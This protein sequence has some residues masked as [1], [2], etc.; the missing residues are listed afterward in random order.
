MSTDCRYWWRGGVLLTLIAALSAPVHA[1]WVYS[2]GGVAPTAAAFDPQ[3]PV[4]VVFGA[5][6]GYLVDVSDPVLPR[7]QYWGSREGAPPISLPSVGGARDVAL[8][9]GRLLVSWRWRSSGAPKVT[10]FDVSDPF[11]IWPGT[12]VSGTLPGDPQA[13]ALVNGVAA[14]AYHVSSSASDPVLVLYALGTGYSL[15]EL[16]RVSIAGA[17]AAAPVGER[18]AVGGPGGVD[19]V[20]LDDP[21]T[22]MVI[23]HL[24]QIVEDLAFNGTVLVARQLIDA[25]HSRLLTIDV[26]DPTDP[27]LLGVLEGLA[28]VVSLATDGGFAYLGRAIDDGGGWQGETVVVS[29][30]DPTVPTVVGTIATGAALGVAVRDGV[31]VVAA[32]EQG[33]RV[34]RLDGPAQLAAPPV[35][36]RARW[37]TDAAG[38]DGRIYVA[39]AGE[40]VW[41]LGRGPAGALSELGLWQRDSLVGDGRVAGSGD[42]VCLIDD[43]QLIM[44]DVSE[45]GAPF[46]LAELPAPA[47]YV[48][49]LVAD[50]RVAA[51]VQIN[52]TEIELVDARDPLHAGYAGQLAV[53]PVQF[54]VES[55]ALDGP[56]LGWTVD[57]EAAHIADVSD[58]WAPVE[59]ASFQP[60]QL[61]PDLADWE[62]WGVEVDRGRAW[63]TVGQNAGFWWNL[64][65]YLV[66]VRDPWATVVL[67][68]YPVIG[69]NVVAVGDVYVAATP[70]YPPASTADVP[71]G[72]LRNPSATSHVPADD[73]L[74]EGFA[75]DGRYAVAVDRT[76]HTLEVAD[77]HDCEVFDLFAD[78]FESAGTSA[79]SD[80]VIGDHVW[81]QPGAAARSPAPQ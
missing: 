56:V 12:S 18:L 13:V 35:R 74:A 24:G 50:D 26:S 42:T 29:L 48:T 41:I 53:G 19:L 32:A 47:E 79:W 77:C 68:Q 63:L 11:A 16:G 57:G 52:A 9:D 76:H 14:V 23:G 46:T 81:T 44:V 33:A 25:S 17:A 64:D 15:Q 66:D 27:Q 1:Q 78:G 80:I 6:G 62:M 75:T 37:Y 8:R 20:D 69:F 7:P 31:V 45:P 43:G 4:A 65:G 54:G 60:G 2:R 40:G 72:D 58:P 61:D 22:P 59:T 67:G 34:A 73:L 38:G 10:L 28:D 51:L 55:L 5:G 21:A 36:F 70:Y 30:A 39:A 3:Q 71:F 49:E